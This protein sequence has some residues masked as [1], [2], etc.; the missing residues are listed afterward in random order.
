MGSEILTVADLV[1]TATLNTQLLAG[2]AGT[3]R[4]VLWAHSCE[5][6]DPEHWLGPHELLMTV[7]LCVP[8]S[9]EDQAAFIAR[10]DD[11][12]LAGIMVAHHA[13]APDFTDEMLHEA[14]SRGF[15]I[16]L[17]GTQTPYA[18]VARH[19]A[20]ANSAEQTLQVLKLSK[21]YHLASYADDADI[22]VRDLSQLLQVGIEV[23]ENLTG[24]TMFE[25]NESPRS[26]TAQLK[27][28]P[29]PLHGSHG[30]Q[31]VISE[32][33][34]E[35]LDSFLLLHLMKV[36]EVTVDRRLN[37]ADRRVEVSTRLMR[38]LLNGTALP[39]IADFVGPH[40]AADGFQVIALSPSA[41]AKVARAVALHKLPVLVGPGRVSHLVLV[42]ASEITTIRDL[43]TDLTPHVGVSSVFTDY[44]DTRVAAV[45]AGKVLAAAQLSDRY[46]TEFEGTTVSV[47][48]R[49]NREAAEI[50]KGVLGPLGEDSQRSTNLRQTLFA[51]LRN[52]RRW[53]DTAA[54]LS[55]H[56]QTL[57]YRLGKIEDETGL[58]LAK[59][60]DL[61]AL[62]IAYQAW[63]ATDRTA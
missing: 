57:A 23:T 60:S 15:P 35:E 55:I 25:A 30:A 46:W 51:Y 22:L 24:L 37:E 16:L 44:A 36:L 48:S 50:V 49:S 43:F 38:S 47:L 4:Q 7:G 18:V 13:Q 34:G 62:W 39:E 32:Y 53:N 63:E 1:A 19:V 5:M 59:S 10:L 45:E 31:L 41:G 58:S 42:P 8:T 2:E 61:S 29:Y 14:D 6:A 21:L 3:G 52:D 54:E 26:E 20:A 9:P 28:R 27:T 12:G 33:P 40:G 11:A 17:A 56:R